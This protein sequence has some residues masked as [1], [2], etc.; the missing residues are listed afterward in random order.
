MLTPVAIIVS[1]YA[2]VPQQLVSTIFPVQCTRK[3]KA[4]M[5]RIVYALYI[6]SIDLCMHVLHYLLF[7]SM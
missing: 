5:E 1:H 6:A 2:L 7:Y 4:V 3:F